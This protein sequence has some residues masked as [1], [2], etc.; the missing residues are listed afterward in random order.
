MQKENKVPE[1]GIV[2]LE[3]KKEYTW[4]DNSNYLYLTCVCAHVAFVYLLLNIVFMPEN[5]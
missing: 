2:V 5:C 1:F 3:V 4:H